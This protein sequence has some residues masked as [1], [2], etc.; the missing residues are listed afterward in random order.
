[1]NSKDVL[2]IAKALKCGWLDMEKIAS[3]QSLLD[4]Y[5]PPKEIKEEEIDYYL[6]CLY[7]GWGYRPTDKE[8]IKEAILQD[9]HGELLEKWGNHIKNDSVYKR[10]VKE[11]FLG[12]VAIRGL[13]GTF[14]EK[15]PDF[16]FTNREPPT[17]R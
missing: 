14:S 16:S 6:E 8:T 2:E 10:M 3:F 1:M 7:Q 15:E 4:G 17:F 13:G 5:N 11:A 9:L 12:M